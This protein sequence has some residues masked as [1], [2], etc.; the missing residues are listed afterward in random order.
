[1]CGLIFIY[2][3]KYLPEFYHQLL[4]EKANKLTNKKEEKKDIS[5]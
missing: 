3:N 2:Y 5:E 4:R 1:M